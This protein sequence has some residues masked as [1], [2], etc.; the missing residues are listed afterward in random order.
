M[1]L[2]SELGTISILVHVETFCKT[3]AHR[4][5]LCSLPLDLQF[6]TK[7]SVDIV[8]VYDDFVP[9]SR[10]AFGIESGAAIEAQRA[11]IAGK[12]SR[13][14]DLGT[15]AEH[16]L[17]D[18]A[19]AFSTC[20]RKAILMLGST[21]LS[22]GTFLIP[23]ANADDYAIVLA[24]RQY[25]EMACAAEGR[26]SRLRDMSAGACMRGS[27][28]WN[29]PSLWGIADTAVWAGALTAVRV[30]SHEFTGLDTASHFEMVP[31]FVEFAALATKSDGLAMPRLEGILYLGSGV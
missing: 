27:W 26:T 4:H 8:H 15:A 9:L 18:C 1:P 3:F 20:E 13:V 31:D 25:P 23:L 21:E 7:A 30:C 17:H 6:G 2:D 14:V 10:L 22:R 11:A 28:R 24:L 19:L 29:A 5:T 16:A 12:D